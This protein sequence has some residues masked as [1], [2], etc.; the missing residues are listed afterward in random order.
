MLLYS[1]PV[2]AMIDPT[3]S[4]YYMETLCY[5]NATTFTPDQCDPSYCTE[6]AVVPTVPDN[7]NIFTGSLILLC[8]LEEPFIF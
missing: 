3:L 6:E 5:N 7:D 4:G 8:T 1:S 2:D